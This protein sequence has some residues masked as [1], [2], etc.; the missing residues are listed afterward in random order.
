MKCNHFIVKNVLGSESVSETE[1]GYWFN[2]NQNTEKKV[3]VCGR[4]TETEVTSPRQSLVFIYRDPV[5]Y[6][7]YCTIL[8]IWL[9]EASAMEHAN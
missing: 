1:K 4:G 3:T 6:V 8:M 7:L 5:A 2:S 9:C